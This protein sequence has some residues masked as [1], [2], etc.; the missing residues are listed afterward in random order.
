M[1]NQ[2]DQ[3]GGLLIYG[4][5]KTTKKMVYSWIQDCVDSCSAA[6]NRTAGNFDNWRKTVQS[7]SEAVDM[8]KSK[9]SMI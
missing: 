8:A 2:L 1:H 4:G 6:G 5:S 9:L 7:V 3:L